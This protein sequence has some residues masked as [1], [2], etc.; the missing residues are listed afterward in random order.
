MG[1][2]TNKGAYLKDGW[3]ILDFIIVV[4]SLI[5]VIF[6]N[7]SVNLSSLR[8]FRVLRPLRTISSIKSLK[9][10][11]VTLFSALPYLANTIIILIFFFLIFAIAGL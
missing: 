5:P 9:V 6:G 3:N 11:L 1:F 10:L 7:S 2:I 8:S 4:V